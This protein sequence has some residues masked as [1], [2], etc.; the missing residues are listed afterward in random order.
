MNL[1]KYL[2]AVQTAEAR[3]QQIAAQI[4]S[5]FE[6]NETSKALELKPQLDAA[7]LEAQKANELYIAMR[8]INGT[9]PDAL[10]PVGSNVQVVKDEADQPWRSGGEF[11]LAVK[12]A[13]LFPRSEDVRLRPLKDATGMSEGVPAEGGY[14]VYPEYSQKMND[15]LFT[16]GEVLSRVSRDPVTGNTMIYNGVDQTSM[17]SGYQLGGIT[18]YWLAEGGSISGSKPKFYQVDLKLKKLGALAYATDE[19]L[20][21]TS[22]LESW[23]LRRVPDVLR[24]MAEDAIVEGSGVGQPEGIMASP[25]LVSVLRTDASKVQYLDIANMW[26]RRW[27]AFSDYVWLVNPDVNPQLDQ[28]ALTVGSDVVPPRFVDYGPDGVMRMKGKP[29]VECDYCQ[30]MGT[31]GDIILAALSQY[32]IIDKGDVATASSIHVSFTTDESCYRFIK[33]VDGES[34]WHSPVT[35][36]HGINTRSPFVCLATASV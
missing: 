30:S 35:P 2:D 28:L 11:L 23:L 4:D 6:A 7:K 22:N 20:M 9:D 3:V 5:A 29:V 27:S 34:L 14:L 24:F 36:L 8:D 25:A 19:Q 16:N 31:T 32:Q 21:D 18:G 17:A 26:A 33:R 13:A 12:N 10:K 1:K 15:T